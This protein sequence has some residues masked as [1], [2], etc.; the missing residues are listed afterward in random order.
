MNIKYIVLDVDGTLTD[1]SIFYDNDRHEIKGFSAKDGLGIANAV[2]CG[3]QFIVITG[4]KSEMVERRMKE[5]KVAHIYQ[6]ISDKLTFLDGFVKENNLDYSEFAYVG[7]DLNDYRSMQKCSFKACPSDAAIE[8]KELAD[9]VATAEGGRGAVREVIEYVLKEQDLWE[10][11][12]SYAI[13]E[14]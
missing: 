13:G 4:R 14:K 1:G 12:V 7:D 9:Y 11:F 10:M 6:G 5:L 2:K 3:I 8:I